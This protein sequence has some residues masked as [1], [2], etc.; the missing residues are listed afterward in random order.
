MSVRVALGARFA[1]AFVRVVLI[2]GLATG[3]RAYSLDA[4]VPARAR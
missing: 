2:A 3:H 4:S 1:A